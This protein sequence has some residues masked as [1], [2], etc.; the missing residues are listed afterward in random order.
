MKEHFNLIPC[1]CC[2]CQDGKSGHSLLHLS[3][4]QADTELFNYLLQIPTVNVNLTT[5]SRLTALDIA[6]MLS[7]YD[8]V[9]QLRSVAGEHSADYVP[10]SGSDSDE[11]RIH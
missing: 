5:Y 9:R 2:C 7:R 8:M 3:V 6:D 4:K 1:Y 10:D 11:V